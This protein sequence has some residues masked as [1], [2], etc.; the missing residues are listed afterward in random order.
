MNNVSYSE[1]ESGGKTRP[2][3]NLEPVNRGLIKPA[4]T[5]G[6]ITQE[7]SKTNGEQPSSN[8]PRQ[9]THDLAKELPQGIVSSKDEREQVHQ[10]YLALHKRLKDMRQ[11]VGREFGR[12]ADLKSQLVHWRRKVVG[13][14]ARIRV[15]LQPEREGVRLRE[16]RRR[17][18]G[19]MRIYVVRYREGTQQTIHAVLTSPF[20][21]SSGSQ[22]SLLRRPG[23]EYD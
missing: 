12:T 20:R 6:I 3:A 23:N 17:Y 10:Q 19:Y 21:L 2:L 13:G 16:R 7:S 4:H 18:T 11:Y 8:P 1:E 22:W 5:N 9:I 14:V 15:R